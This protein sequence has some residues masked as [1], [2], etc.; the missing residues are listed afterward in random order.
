MGRKQQRQPGSAAAW[1]PIRIEQA[2][3]PRPG[4][5]RAAI[6]ARTSTAKQ[7]TIDAQVA[8]CRQRCRERG[9]KVKYILQDEGLSGVDSE[10]PGFQRLMDLAEDQ[11]IDVVVV[12]KIDRLAR[13]LAHAAALEDVFRQ[14]GAAIHSCTEPIDTTTSSGR[15]VFGTLANAAQ[16]EREIIKERTRMG[17]EYRA[18]QGSWLNNNIPYGYRRTKNNHLR[19]HGPEAQI[20]REI[21][22]TYLVAKSYAETAGLLNTC[23]VTY[24]GTPWTVKRIRTVVENEIYRGKLT[25]G[26]VAR[27]VERLRV[28]SDDLAQRVKEQRQKD[29]RHG[30]RASE[31][32][33]EAS[34]ANVFNQYFQILH[35][36]G[37]PL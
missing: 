7:Q 6:Y 23:G 34:I 24:R 16:L 27:P 29:E 26:R 20:V 5:L 28:V 30:E 17:M 36:E 8:L 37:T 31:L 13:S 2:E 15:F 21:F 19:I 33:R 3:E 12:W 10:R 11:A 25:V 4:M 32:V 1:Q 22:E 14:A 9:W 18:L 35:D